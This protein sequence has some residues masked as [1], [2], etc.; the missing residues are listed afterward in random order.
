VLIAGLDTLNKSTF[1]HLTPDTAA[2][3]GSLELPDQLSTS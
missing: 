2:M 3:M 1:N